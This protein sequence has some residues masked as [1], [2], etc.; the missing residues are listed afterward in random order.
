LKV[1]IID[2]FGALFSSIT[3]QLN[4]GHV[5]LATTVRAMK[6]LAIQFHILFLVFFIYDVEFFASMTIHL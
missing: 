5:L 4:D 6:E 3:G 2:S 1:V